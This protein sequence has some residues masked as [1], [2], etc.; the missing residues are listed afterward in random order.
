MLEMLVLLLIALGVFS[1][2]LVPM[3]RPQPY[4]TQTDSEPQTVATVDEQR[5]A[6]SADRR[7]VRDLS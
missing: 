4:E 1:Y 7:P 3:V 2:V 6:V 5:E